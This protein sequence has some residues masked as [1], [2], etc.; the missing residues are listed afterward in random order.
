ML[1]FSWSCLTSE[2]YARLSRQKSTWKHSGILR[3]TCLLTQKSPKYSKNMESVFSARKR[4]SE[5]FDVFSVFSGFL[6]AWIYLG[7]GG[8]VLSACRFG[9]SQVRL[10]NACIQTQQ[11][12][13]TCCLC[14]ADLLTS[15][16]CFSNTSN[17]RCSRVQSHLLSPA[18]CFYTSK[19]LF[20]QRIF[21]ISRSR[22]LHS[23]AARSRT[24]TSSGK[25]SFQG[26]RPI[27]GEGWQ[28]NLVGALLQCG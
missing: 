20:F 4:L 13:A 25:L 19:N 2:F 15:R 23:P 9:C 26:E 8:V 14:S 16:C 7:G 28:I 17:T 24:L 10:H 12:N 6:R 1:L 22:F 11:V 27:T 3:R 5:K 18:F 21:S